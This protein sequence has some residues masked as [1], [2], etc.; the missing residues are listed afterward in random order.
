MRRPVPEGAVA[1]SAAALAAALTAS[2]LAAAAATA[3]VAASTFATLAAFS[4][5]AL[6]A[7]PTTALLLPR[8]LNFMRLWLRPTDRSEFGQR[9]PT[10]EHRHDRPHLQFPVLSRGWAGAVV[11]G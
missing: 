4:A 1:A 2:T 6:S 10:C 3:A 8:R 9:V 7:C 11:R 5:A